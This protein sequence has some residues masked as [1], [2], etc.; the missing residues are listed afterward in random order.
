MTEPRK[1]KVNDELTT[2][3][4]LQNGFVCNGRYYVYK[5]CLYYFDETK[6][7]YITLKI[8]IT[9]D[10]EDGK[11]LLIYNVTGDD[12]YC[13]PAFYDPNVR[14]NNY[15]YESSVKLF[16]KVIDQMVTNHILKI[17]EQ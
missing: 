4:L 7:P 13:Y 6:N 8:D 10:G 15:V 17:E 3:Q 1:F 9:F 12:G 11:P 16:N 2:D 14:H 5:K